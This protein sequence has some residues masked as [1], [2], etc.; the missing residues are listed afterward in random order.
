MRL[1]DL[2]YSDI[3][4]LGLKYL[5]YRPLRG[6]TSQRTLKAKD[7][8]EFTIFLLTLRH[9]AGNYSKSMLNVE[10]VKFA[11]VPINK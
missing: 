6:A 4:T 7:C 3:D 5:I 10:K 11:T 2:R 9:C 1:S 8:T